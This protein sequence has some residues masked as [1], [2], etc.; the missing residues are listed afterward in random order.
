M[1]YLVSP[2]QGCGAEKYRRSDGLVVPGRTEPAPQWPGQYA[3]CRVEAPVRLL[4]GAKDPVI[5]PTLLRVY[6]RRI[7]DLKLE[8]VPDAGHWIVEERPELVLERLR[9]FLRE[10]RR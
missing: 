7:T 1:T 8:T 4:H 3:Y 6:E 2:S 10:I 5:T 9:E